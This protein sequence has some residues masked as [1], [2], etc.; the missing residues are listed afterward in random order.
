TEQGYNTSGRPVQYDEDTALTWTHDVP[1]NAVPLIVVEGTAYR[2][3]RL[4]LN[5]SN[6][7]TARFISLDRVRLFKH[8]AGG[9]NV[10][11]PDDDG[12]GVG[13]TLVWDLDGGA[14]R[15]VKMD[16]NNFSGSG[17]GDMRLLVPNSFF[18]V[19]AGVCPYDAGTGDPCGIYIYLYSQFG[20]H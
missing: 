3:F 12:F 8:N 1:L 17:K 9:V 2:E 19:P 5:E 13:A 15:W 4:D 10:A 20:V 14:D 7:Q 16:A 6:T 11:N 18:N